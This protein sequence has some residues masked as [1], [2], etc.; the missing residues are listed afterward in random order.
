MSNG[1]VERIILRNLKIWW[2]E[3]YLG[4]RGHKILKNKGQK[5]AK[6]KYKALYVLKGRPVILV[7]KGSLSAKACV[8]VCVCVCVCDT[9]ERERERERE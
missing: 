3:I 1:I 4:N 5:V 8:C 6:E 9:R 7:W 2:G